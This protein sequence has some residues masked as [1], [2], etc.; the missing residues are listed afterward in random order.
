MPHGL[1]STV[2]SGSFGENPATGKPLPGK[3]RK[4]D[5]SKRSFDDDV[6]VGPSIDCCG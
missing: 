5:P 2:T 1:A 6:R 3:L 4:A